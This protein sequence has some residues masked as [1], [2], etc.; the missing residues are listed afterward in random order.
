MT[1]QTM[2]QMTVDDIFSTFYSYVSGGPEVVRNLLQII[3]DE[4]S[5]KA[6]FMW[7][8][9]FEVDEE[10]YLSK[11]VIRDRNTGNSYVHMKEMLMAEW[12]EDTIIANKEYLEENYASTN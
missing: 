8:A 10:Y 11:G 6:I 2:Y 1:S 12:R 9:D 3:D 7:F 5:E 4:R